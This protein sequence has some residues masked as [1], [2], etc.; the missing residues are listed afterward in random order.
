MSAPFRHG[1]IVRYGAGEAAL[2]QVNYSTPAQRGGYLLHGLQCMGIPIREHESL[3]RPANERDLET[4]SK[5]ARARG[6][7]PLLSMTPAR[8]ASIRRG[9]GLTRNELARWL[10]LA[11]A[12]AYKTLVDWET[13]A[14]PVTGPAESAL[15]AFEAG[16]VPAHVR[17]GSSDRKPAKERA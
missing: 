11:P 2:M 8:L 12:N 7:N 17:G 13:G 6:D 3:C 10:K 4:W 16:F 5:H 14:K 1:D 9:L 15:E